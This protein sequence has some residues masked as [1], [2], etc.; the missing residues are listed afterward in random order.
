MSEDGHTFPVGGM[1]ITI[2]DE[3]LWMEHSD[4]C[5][6]NKST[7]WAVS[8]I[9]HSIAQTTSYVGHWRSTRANSNTRNTCRTCFYMAHTPSWINH[10]I[11]RTS[12][13][14]LCF[15]QKSTTNQ[16]WLQWCSEWFQQELQQK[17]KWD[18]W[19]KWWGNHMLVHNIHENKR[20]LHFH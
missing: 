13:I 1:Q 11:K 5:L 18:R 7:T 15:K 20:K 14:K 2:D 4:R 3:W 10:R 16:S 17:P 12:T 6:E 9:N 8:I 19:I